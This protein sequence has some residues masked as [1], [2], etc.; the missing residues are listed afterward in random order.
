MFALDIH[1]LSKKYANIV[2]IADLSLAVERRQIFGFVGPDG[3]GKTSLF[4]I[5]CGILR[6]SSGRAWVLGFDTVAES[7]KLKQEL[8]IWPENLPFMPI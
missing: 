2:A 7:E 4:R 6:P 3:A 1:N 5:L 8:G